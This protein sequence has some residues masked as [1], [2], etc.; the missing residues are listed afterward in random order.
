MAKLKVCIPSC[1][2]PKKLKALLHVLSN[3]AVVD[4]VLVV[5]STSLEDILNQSL[6]RNVCSNFPKVK[7]I[8]LP[9]SGPSECRM[10]GG[11]RLKEI[12]EYILFMD[13]DLVPRS[14]AIES[15]LKF[16]SMRQDIDIC[17]GV[18]IDHKSGKE[19]R[20]R[21]LGSRYVEE[22]NS[23]VKCL[24]K[25]YVYVDRE[26]SE[27]GFTILDDLQASLLLNADALDRVS[28]DRS[29]PFFLELYDFYYACLSQKLKLACVHEAVFDH[30]PG[31][32]KTKTRR[33]NHEEDLRK[34]MIY[35]YNKWGRFPLRNE[36]DRL[37]L[38]ELL[39]EL[40]H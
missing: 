23:G 13:D 28:F 38:R 19:P 3:V 29:Y 20:A 31:G 35:F 32:Y 30:Y 39:S 12:A 15:M 16:M 40:I 2:R 22:V 33:S 6:Y 34:G 27:A 10:F 5:N 25:N 14:G 18:W 21:P 1:S 7:V 26:R 4:E 11:L 8:D 9:G 37:I 24:S 36:K 17:S